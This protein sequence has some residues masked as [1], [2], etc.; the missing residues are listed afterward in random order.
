MQTVNYMEVGFAILASD[1]TANHDV[2][3][4]QPGIQRRKF[5]LRLDYNALPAPFIEPKR[6]IISDRMPCADID[7]RSSRLPSKGQREMII[8]EIL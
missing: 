2:A 7:V 3:R 4:T 8:L 1:Q 5:G 6:Y